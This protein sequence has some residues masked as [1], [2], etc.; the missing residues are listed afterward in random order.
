MINFPAYT[1]LKNRTSSTISLTNHGVNAL[2]MAAR[3]LLRPVE[4]EV[5][6]DLRPKSTSMVDEI[7]VLVK[8]TLPYPSRNL[9]HTN[10]D[11]HQMLKVGGLSLLPQKML[12]DLLRG[13]HY[14]MKA[15]ARH[16]SNKLSK[17]DACKSKPAKIEEVQPTRKIQPGVR[18][19]ISYM[20]NCALSQ[21]IRSLKRR[22]GVQER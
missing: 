15:P 21:S 22:K 20:L 5:C 13:Q 12:L 14:N 10:E 8:H 9:W 1:F 17:K 7:I 16:K 3:A 11:L 18:I 2:N 19:T 4:D 6:L